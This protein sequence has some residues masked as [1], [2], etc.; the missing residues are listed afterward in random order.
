MHTPLGDIPGLTLTTTTSGAILTITG[1]RTTTPTMVG[2]G[3]G[4]S[5][6]P[7]IVGLG[8]GRLATH[9]TI[10]T[11]AGTTHGTTTIT[12]TT[13]M[14]VVTAPDAP[15]VLNSLTVH[16]PVAVASR[17]PAHSVQAL[18]V[19]LV[20]AIWAPDAVVP[21]LRPPAPL[22]QASVTVLPATAITTLQPVA[23]TIVVATPTPAAT[24]AVLPTINLR[25]NRQAT[26]PEVSIAVARAVAPPVALT[27]VH[28]VVAVVD[29]VV[30][31]YHPIPYR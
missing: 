28:A 19:Y 4:A 17:V 25:A 26:T 3:V 2:H 22:V 21:T 11:T 7:T 18:P 10:T 23:A 29:A 12:A 20:P 14:A 1:G 27:A 5:M 13:T 30:D 6:I 24:P 16:L 15:M 9:I 8:D 31:N